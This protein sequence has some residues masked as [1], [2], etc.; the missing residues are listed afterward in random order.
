M[1][2]LSLVLVLVFHSK[3]STVNWSL[4]GSDMPS[5]LGL[6]LNVTVLFFS[7]DLFG[8]FGILNNFLTFSV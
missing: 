4:I 7:H 8:I 3:G 2:A 1:L 6:V 5:A